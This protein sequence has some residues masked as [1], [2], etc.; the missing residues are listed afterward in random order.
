MK[1]WYLLMRIRRLGYCVAYKATLEAGRSPHSL[2]YTFEQQYSLLQS[3]SFQ[4]ESRNSNKMAT[5]PASPSDHARKE[6]N[7]LYKAGKLKEGTWLLKNQTHHCSIGLVQDIQRLFHIKKLLNSTPTMLRL[8]PI[9]RQHTS[10]WENTHWRRQ[11]AM[12]L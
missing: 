9:C 3:S 5:I 11:P 6:G 4:E 1:L 8:T 10:N 12:Q 2:D 7:D